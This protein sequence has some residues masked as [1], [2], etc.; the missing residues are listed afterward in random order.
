MRAVKRLSDWKVMEI[1]ASHWQKHIWACLEIPAG[2]SCEIKF[3]SFSHP[4]ANCFPTQ[5]GHCRTGNVFVINN[6]CTNSGLFPVP[7]V[8]FCLCCCISVPAWHCLHCMHL[9]TYLAETKS[10]CYLIFLHSSTKFGGESLWKL[11]LLIIFCFPILL[12][13][14]ILWLICIFIQCYLPYSHTPRRQKQTDYTLFSLNVVHFSKQIKYAFA[15]RFK[16][17]Y[18][19]LSDVTLVKNILKN[20]GL[21]IIIICDY[22]MRNWIK[23]I[24]HLVV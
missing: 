10:R 15:V 17:F 1:T 5:N 8:A 21:I 2:F 6:I 18:C 11:Y 24:E 4:S 19:I 7:D 23:I 22:I 9:C 14:Q 3:F 16:Y 20:V 12:P 13:G